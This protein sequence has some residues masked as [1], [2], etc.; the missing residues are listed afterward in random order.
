MALHHAEPRASHTA[1]VPPRVKAV[2]FDRYG[3]ADVLR[4]IDLPMPQAGPGEIRV[5]VRAAG[6]RP[7]DI[8]LR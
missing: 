7:G 1:P 6:V 3:P 5:R 2:V 4:A 8:A